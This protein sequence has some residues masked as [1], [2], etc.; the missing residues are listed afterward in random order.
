MPLYPQPPT[1][2]RERGNTPCSIGTSLALESLGGFGE[3]PSK[4]PP[5]HRFDTLWVNTRTVFRNL[6]Q[7]VPTQQRS[8]LSVDEL[9]DGFVEDIEVIRTTL[10][11]IALHPVTLV[12]YYVDY[13][14]IDR[15]FPLAVLK[16]TRT[17][18]QK[19]E[20]SLEQATLSIVCSGQ[21]FDQTATLVNA[22]VL[23]K[24]GGGHCAMLTHYPSD[25]LARERFKRL[26]LLESHT[27]TLKPPSQW[28]TKL[29][30]GQRYHRL[31]FN[32][33]T[34]QVFGDQS[35]LFVGFKPTIKKALLALAEEQR[36]T[37]VTTPDKIRYSLKHMKDRA[38][39]EFFLKLL[40]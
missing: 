21:V 3:Y 18:N 23:I 29:T 38:L 13:R 17:Q 28:Y 12:F 37:P 16:H 14:A 1:Y 19:K 30:G 36:W 32:R 25:L 7:S 35:Q 31:P 34:L 6:Y 4:D 33:L 8:Q 15:V 26:T 5:I 10:A 11:H 40:H 20:A 27:G 22:S 9:V 39:G 2:T 24:Q